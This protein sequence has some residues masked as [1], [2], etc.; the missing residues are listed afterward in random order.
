MNVTPEI[1]RAEMAYRVE[2]AR[3]SAQ[4]RA[5]PAPRTHRTW[6]DRLRQRLTAGGP[7]V[8]NGTPRAA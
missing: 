6:Y 2:Q 7:T 1:V 3:K 4:H 5:V 8:V